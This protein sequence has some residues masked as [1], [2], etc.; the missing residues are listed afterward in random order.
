MLSKGRL[1]SLSFGPLQVSG[2]VFKLAALFVKLLLHGHVYAAK[3]RRLFFLVELH[4]LH[5][6]DVTNNIW[7]S[8]INGGNLNIIDHSV[9]ISLNLASC[10][11]FLLSFLSLLLLLHLYKL[12]KGAFEVNLAPLPLLR[13]W[14]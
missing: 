5:I 8:L 11:Y 14:L 6:F 12:I 10:S 3:V 1:S 9:L 2:D 13:H 7:A 4:A